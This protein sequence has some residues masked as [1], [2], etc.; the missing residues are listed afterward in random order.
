MLTL[1]TTLKSS[2]Y[3]L[4]H[5]ITSLLSTRV[6]FPK[7]W[8]WCFGVKSMELFN[9]VKCVLQICSRLPRIFFLSISFQRNKVLKPLPTTYNL[10]IENFIDFPLDVSI[11]ADDWWRRYLLSSYNGIQLISFQER[12][13]EDVMNL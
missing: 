6:K 3:K 8:S 10:G 1:V 11:R 4:V 2:C 7:I 13:M 5:N 9:S 12:N